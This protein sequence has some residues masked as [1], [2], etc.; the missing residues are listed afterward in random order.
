MPTFDPTR[1]LARSFTW[2]E[3]VIT[4]HRSLYESNAQES[5]AVLPALTSLAAMLQTVR[6]HY[7]VPVMVHSGYRGPALNEAIGGSKS[8]QHMRGEAADFHVAGHGLREVF[9]WLRD[10]SG[11]PYGQIILEGSIPNRPTWVHLS[12]GEPWRRLEDCR[13]PM[14]WDRS[15]GYRWARG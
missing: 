1:R 2:G 14:T 8:S 5:A 11:L 10:C 13:Q 4:N 3:L 9:V 6:D 12:L 7:G 15:N